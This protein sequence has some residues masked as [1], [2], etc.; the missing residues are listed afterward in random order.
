MAQYVYAGAGHW[1]SAG[2]GE[3][4][5]GLMRKE[6]GSGKWEFLST[7]L[8]PKAEVR[9]IA[10]HPDNPATVYVGTQDGPYRSTDS[11]D[12]WEKLPFPDAAMLVW[13]IVLHPQDPN[14]LYLGTSPAAVYRSDNGGDSWQRLSIIESRGTVN[15]GFDMRVIRLTIDPSNPNEIYAGLE[16][17]G[18]IRSLDGGKTW[19]DCSE[20]LLRLA[21]LD[22]LKSQIG[23]DT[24]VEGMMDSHAITVSASQPG[25]VFL[26]TRMG[27]F[28]SA[29][30]G[31]TWSDMEVGRFSPLTYARDVQ[32]APDNPNVLYAALSPAARS[33]DGS[34]Y[35]S[36]DLGQTWAR[37]DHDVTP[38]S[39]MMTIALSR[40]DPDVVHCATR[41]GQVFGT[42]DGGATW[43]EYPLPEGLQDIY[44]VACG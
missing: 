30:Q 18:V 24:D 27:L 32:V 12:T 1:T 35:R 5:G 16:V 39:T 20:D 26:A 43:Q 8:P 41:G 40:Q 25:K 38:G 23:S 28:N 33:E 9:T 7:G 14:I 11:G 21:K 3:H 2:S 37:F 15:M 36:D 34:L 19:E 29:D 42:Q 13:T 4:A 6:V 44:A 17:G 22:H 10:I 31:S